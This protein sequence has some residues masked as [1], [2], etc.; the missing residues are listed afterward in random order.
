MLQRM[1]RIM[2]S[3]ELM[4]V[5]GEVTNPKSERRSCRIGLIVTSLDLTERRPPAARACASAR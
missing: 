2:V 1:C 5:L 3:I 4:C